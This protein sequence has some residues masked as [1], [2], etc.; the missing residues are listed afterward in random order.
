M[1]VQTTLDEALRSLELLTSLQQKLWGHI[2]VRLLEIQ[3]WTPAGL[4]RV[5]LTEFGH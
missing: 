4:S 5:R 1:Q 3:K 2:L